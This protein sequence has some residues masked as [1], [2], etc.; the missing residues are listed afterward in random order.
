MAVSEVF[1]EFNE[2]FCDVYVA[3]DDD[4]AVFP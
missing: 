4:D 2:F 1:V 3:E